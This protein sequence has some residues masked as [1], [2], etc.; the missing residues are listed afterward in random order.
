MRRLLGSALVVS[1]VIVALAVFVG[2]IYYTQSRTQLANEFAEAQWMVGRYMATHLRDQ[3]QIASLTASELAGSLSPDGGLGDPAR[4]DFLAT[5]FAETTGTFFR[6]AGDGQVVAVAPAGA[7]PPP[8]DCYRDTLRRMEAGQRPWP[9]FHRE[10]DGTS[11][12]VI[13]RAARPPA[14]GTVGVC[15]DL[16]PV[17]KGLD[18]VKGVQTQFILVD[19]RDLTVLAAGVPLPEPLTFDQ[20]FSTETGRLTATVKS[21]GTG[22]DNDARSVLLSPSGKPEPFLVGVAAL[23]LGG[24]R[25]VLVASAPRGPTV[26]GYLRQILYWNFGMGLVVL[27]ALASFGILVGQMRVTARQEAQRREE[28]NWLYQISLALM[29]AS[30]LDDVLGQLAEHAREL[31]HA[32]GATIALIDPE[33]DEIHFRRVSS[34]R[35]DVA[36]KLLGLRV[37]RGQG[38]IG[39]VIEHGEPVHVVDAAKDERFARTVDEQSGAHTMSLMCAPLLDQQGKPLGA[40]ELVNNP[41]NP[42][43]QSDLVL[44]QSLALMASAAVERAMWQEMEAQQERLRREMDIARTVQQG[45]L[46]KA[47]P[48]FAG[49]DLYGANTP[50]REVGGDFYD[51]IQI[52][53]RHVGV[54]IADVADKGLGA[55]MFMVMCRSL[56][57]AIASREMSP[58]EV[59]E[60]LNRQILEMS[61]SDLFVTAFY[62]VLDVS[63]RT[64]TYTSA[65]HNPPLLC[66]ADG[67]VTRLSMQGTALGVIAP[68][69]LEEAAVHLA[70]GDRLVLYTDGITEAI[71][72][73]GD[74]FGMARLEAV[75]G[76]SVGDDAHRTVE[77]VLAQLADF[78][79]NEPQFD[80]IT[81]A[82]IAV[83]GAE[84]PS[85]LLLDTMTRG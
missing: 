79:G 54:V 70:P 77:R 39:W 46:P 74:A 84:E 14:E 37:P 4:V 20:V 25:L 48:Q 78:V 18:L 64:F 33:T 72:P 71:N 44:L 11:Q 83:T 82:V 59:L 81:L 61:T 21:A 52:S 3:Y 68:V 36:A 57:Y 75:L 66:R 5:L 69:G 76:A 28:R 58:A 50:A 41:D 53:D 24:R 23:E 27:V 85:D 67:S 1:G 31:F 49:I 63:A 17:L 19:P 45:L 35:E 73:A 62:G 2:S 80:D 10:A 56:L 16:T 47:F 38:V 22:W 8:A 26:E 32:E 43:P 12:M 6:L 65:G 15:L 55:A 34:R 9:S 40:L 29:S 7:T 60:D 13:L 30:K 51:F 42:F